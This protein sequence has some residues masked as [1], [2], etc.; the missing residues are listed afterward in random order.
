MSLHVEVMGQG[1]DLVLLHGWGMHGGVWRG[2]CETLAGRFRLHA[3]DL[4]GMGHSPSCDPYSL[5]HLARVLASALPAQAAVCGW[6]LGGQVA[7]QLALEFPDQVSR[8]ILVG[9]TPCFVKTADW[10]HGVDAEVFSAFARQ[11]EADY[12]SSMERFL[13]LQAFGGESSRKLMRALREQF[14]ARPAPSPEALQQA[15]NVLL[16]TD[17]RERLPQLGQPA[18]I[19]HGE[20]DMLAPQAAA[21]WMAKALPQACLHLIPGGSHAPFLSHPAAFASCVNTFL[22]QPFDNSRAA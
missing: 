8:L 18:L 21:H 5:P 19:V 4:P 2:V 10:P 1:P 16:Q 7:M 14:S 22:D 9:S 12:H 6:S 11:V 15:L 3:I 20:H 13:G 17:L